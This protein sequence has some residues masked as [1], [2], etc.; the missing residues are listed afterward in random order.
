[1]L[2]LGFPVVLAV[3]VRLPG[4]CRPLLGHFATKNVTYAMIARNWVLGRASFWH[5]TMDCMAGGDR[6]WHLLEVPVSAYLAG[7]GWSIFGGSLDVWG[8][9]SCIAFSAGAVALMFALVR[10]WHGPIAACGASVALALSPSAVIFGQS[11]MLEAPLMFFAL[12][13]FFCLERWLS[14]NRRRWLLLAATSFA[15]LLLTKIYMLVLALPLAA[16]VWRRMANTA[17]AEGLRTGGEFIL[18]AL[19][20]VAP[21]ALWYAH[22]WQIAAPGEPSSAHVFYSVRQ[23]ATVHGWPHPLLTSADF[24]RRLLDDL[25]GWMLTPIGAA[26][27]LAGFWNSAWRRHAAWLAAT[28]IL[29][30]AL[31]SK[32]Y[33]LSY[34]DLAILPVFC[35]LVGLGWQAVYERIKPGRF[36][37]ACTLLAAIV[38]SLRH[39]AHPA[40]ATP[41]EDRGV[42]AAAA[43]VRARTRPEEPVATLHGAAS[44]LLYYCDRPGWAFSVNDRRLNE[45]LQIARERGARWLVVADLDSALGSRSAAAL[46]KLRAVGEGEDFRIYELAE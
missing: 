28:A 46:A 12:A 26:L 10:R 18:A 27:A 23:S 20:A 14:G 33:E 39:A 34:Y 44:D 9:A 13:S 45:R 4:I 30:A 36:G 1:M 15:L 37:I 7:A 21:A 24:Y 22:V 31:P 35:L 3:L 19:A 38:F 2:Q 29:V 25:S 41:A 43:A 32:F 6:G 42:L 16:L 5:P 40:F 17:R 11:F 8:R